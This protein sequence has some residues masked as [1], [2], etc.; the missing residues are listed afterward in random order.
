MTNRPQLGSNRH[1]ERNGHKLG[2]R[3]GPTGP[4]TELGKQRSKLNAVKYGIF[5]SVMLLRSESKGEFDSLVSGLM[6]HY[7]PVGSLEEALVDQLATSLWRFRRLLMAESAEISKTQPAE[8]ISEKEMLR[9]SVVRSLMPSSGRFEM[10]FLTNSRLDLIQTLGALKGIR[11]DIRKHGLSWERDHDRLEE[12]FGKTREP[13]EETE[14]PDKKQNKERFIRKYREAVE[15]SRD[16][17]QLAAQNAEAIVAELDKMTEYLDA[18]NLEWFDEEGI[19]RYRATTAALIPSPEVAEKLLRYQITL[20]R[21]IERT[22]AQLER[23]QRMRLGQPVAPP[24]QI[25][26]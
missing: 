19:Q 24:V 3:R 14:D 1:E 7:Q 8:N 9:N 12:V 23:L 2:K 18:I 17:Q 13:L 26:G 22:M 25:A 6:A 15:R 4:R 10:A 11:D 16:N 21:S 20:E 5:S